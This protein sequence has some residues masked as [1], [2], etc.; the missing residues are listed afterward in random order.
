MEELNDGEVIVWTVNG[1]KNWVTKPNG[2]EIR[3][4]E[5]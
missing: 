2:S 4:R 1:T 3:M 5:S